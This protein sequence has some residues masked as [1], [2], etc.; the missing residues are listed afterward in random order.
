MMYFSGCTYQRRY[1]RLLRPL[2]ENPAVCAWRRHVQR[3]QSA[4]AQVGVFDTWY[5][6]EL[7]PLASTMNSIGFA[8][9]QRASSRSSQ[10]SNQEPDMYRDVLRLLR[11][12]ASSGHWPRISKGRAKLLQTDAGT[13]SLS[14]AAGSTD[15]IG[16]FSLGK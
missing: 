8:A 5:R 15:A 13:D 10:Y 11:A 2:M 3:Q 14:G 6:D 4:R 9:K 12:A 7:L 16:S 1:D